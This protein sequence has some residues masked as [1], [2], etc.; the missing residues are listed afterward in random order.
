DSMTSAIHRL[1]SYLFDENGKITKKLVIFIGAGVSREYGIPTTWGFAELFFKSPLSGFSEEEKLKVEHLADDDFIK[2][3]ISEFS[4][5]LSSETAYS[6][7][8][9]HERDA[10]GKARKEKATYDWIISLWKS[11]YIQLVFTTNF[12]TL[13]EETIRSKYTDFSFS[14][15]DYSDLQRA[16]IPSNISYNQ[17]I[18]L[19]G[20]INRTSMLWTETE[21]EKAVTEEVENFI[22]LNSY[23]SPI[24]LLGYTASEKPIRRILKKHNKLK[25]SVNP[26]RLED[27]KSLHEVISKDKFNQHVETFSAT[28]IQKLYEEIFRRTGDKSLLLSFENIKRK[29]IKTRNDLYFFN[30][31]TSKHIV[32]ESGLDKINKIFKSDERGLLY[33]VH[34]ESGVGKS[35]YFKRYVIYDSNEELR[36]FIPASEL[37]HSL[38]S[39]FNKFGDLTIHELVRLVAF[40]DKKL[41]IIIDGL[42]ELI[43]N[44]MTISLLNEI[45][46]ILD[47]SYLDSNSGFIKVVIT[48]RTDFWNMFSNIKSINRK[49]GSEIEFG[50]L[51]KDEVVKA[52]HHNHPYIYEEIKRNPFLAKILSTPQNLSHI[53]SIGSKGINDI[54]ESKL[55]EISFNNLIER[56]SETSLKTVDDLYEVSMEYLIYCYRKRSILPS[57]FEVNEHREKFESL[58]SL[59]F[60]KKD[61]VGTLQFIDERMGEYLF[62]VILFKE[63]FYIRSKMDVVDI[64]KESLS[65]MYEAKS[66]SMKVHIINS[67]FFFINEL[68]KDSCKALLNSDDSYIGSIFKASVIRKGSFTLTNEEIYEPLYLAVSMVDSENFNILNEKLMSCEG[69]DFKRLPLNYSAKMYTRSSIEFYK[70]IVEKGMANFD[71]EKEQRKQLTLIMDM[72]IALSLRKGA[73][74][75][76]RAPLKKLISRI[77]KDYFVD[78]VYESLVNNRRSFFHNSSDD[79]LSDIYDIEWIVKKRLNKAVRC[80]VFSLSNSHIIFLMEQPACVR[81]V[82]K[83]LFV[84]DENKKRFEELLS[85]I[86][87]INSIRVVDTTLGILSYLAKINPEEYYDMAYNFQVTL[88]IKHGYIFQW[89]HAID[90]KADQHHQ[91]DPLVPF[92]TSILHCKGEASFLEYFKEHTEFS[93]YTIGKLAQKTLLDFPLSTIKLLNLYADRSDYMDNPEIRVATRGLSRF[94]ASTFWEYGSEALHKSAFSTSKND[95][96]ELNRIVSQVRDYDWYVV[97]KDASKDNV[98]VRAWRCIIYKYVNKSNI[99]SFISYFI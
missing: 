45:N 75:L 31:K 34:G 77:N 25:V 74:I 50:R 48:T 4:S 24:L 59:G 28:F 8:K 87:A 81:L 41:H 78:L 89:K 20:D 66:T 39:W 76:A 23:N 6:F 92:A 2:L 49:Y 18:K 64:I 55:F 91:Y 14:V 13:L 96:A 69:Y 37:T 99:R 67:I 58:V 71:S 63:Y 46:G 65:V 70:F 15:A 88:N 79:N 47:K 44:K 16:Q 68:S 3:F 54:S 1:L 73:S 97:L 29:I 12:D 94:S 10:I 62:G 21:F 57:I 52:V 82:L 98:S 33:I 22:T 86:L 61:R 83:F 80:G 30:D 60:L 19:A 42:N 56:S 43:S 32:R 11:G 17:I 36:V 35:Y 51:S 7:F 72:S 85:D 40:L 95:L 53:I 38:S 26:K 5:K 90:G 9:E 93:P 27:I 84:I